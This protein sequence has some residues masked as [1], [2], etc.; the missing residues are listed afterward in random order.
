MPS[1]SVSRQHKPSTSKNGSE[2]K[3]RSRRSGKER[4]KK[5]RRVSSS[6]ED[7]DVEQVVQ[8]IREEHRQKEDEV[9]AVVKEPTS[10][11]K[12]KSS[13]YADPMEDDLPVDCEIEIRE[14][15]R[16]EDAENNYTHVENEDRTTDMEEENVKEEHV[17]YET[18]RAVQAI[19]PQ[20]EESVKDND[21]AYSSGDEHMKNTAD[22]KSARSTKTTTKQNSC[23][24]SI[25]PE[26]KSK[27]SSSTASPQQDQVTLNSKPTTNH[28]VAESR[29]NSKSSKSHSKSTKGHHETNYKSSSSTNEKFDNQ[30]KSTSTETNPLSPPSRCGTP[31]ANATAGSAHMMSTKYVPTSHPPQSIELLS[32]DCFRYIKRAYTNNTERTNIILELSDA[33]KRGLVQTFTNTGNT[34]HFQYVHQDYKKLFLRRFSI[35]LTW[36][37]EFALKLQPDPRQAQ[38]DYKLLLETTTV[39]SDEKMDPF[40]G[41]RVMPDDRLY[42]MLECIE[43][44]NI[45][46][47]P[48][49]D[50]EMEAINMLNIHHLGDLATIEITSDDTPDKIMLKNRHNSI[51]HDVMHCLAVALAESFNARHVEKEKNK[52]SLDFRDGMCL[53]IQEFPPPLPH[54]Y[55][56]RILG[57]ELYSEF[58]AN[59]LEE[60]AIDT[61]EMKVPAIACLLLETILLHY[62]MYQPLHDKKK[63]THMSRYCVREF[64]KID[65]TSYDGDV[66]SLFVQYSAMRTA[67]DLIAFIA[68]SLT[69]VKGGNVKDIMGFLM[70]TIKINR[71]LVLCI[72]STARSDKTETQL[73]FDRFSIV[74]DLLTQRKSEEQRKVR[75][76]IPNTSRASFSIDYNCDDDGGQSNEQR[77]QKFSSMMYSL[78]NKWEIPKKTPKRPAKVTERIEEEVD[79]PCIYIRLPRYLVSTYE[80]FVNM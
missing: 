80:T 36:L 65:K 28:H 10:K 39:N 68:R 78:S 71:W 59:D 64:S 63:W 35:L 21:G 67:D 11:R 14:P 9:E 62:N 48:E 55:A 66:N 18:E 58:L 54:Y 61:E 22:G 31:N 23:S 57:R 6:E 32:P 19:T 1:R 8:D 72:D 50:K 76:R 37:D 47:K 20:L 7:E 42:T 34:P 5:R 49:D 69:D 44:A 16:D 60:A 29:C 24:F 53:P 70:D 52:E 17:T 51:S 26:K 45:A 56:E 15:N 40:H 43:T 73:N 2:D 46:R 30:K 77:K 38:I 79:V 74:F 41:R 25:L 3:D 13:K 4:E 33:D 27:T 75:K 12:K